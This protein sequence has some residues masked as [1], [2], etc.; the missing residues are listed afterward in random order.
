VLHNASQI[1]DGEH[2][3][4][5][6]HGDKTKFQR[7]DAALVELLIMLLGFVACEQPL[8]FRVAFP[9]N[10][11]DLANEFATAISPA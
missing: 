9:L 3:C 7:R 11:T 8:L 4:E 2:Q 5:Q 10:A 1:E 6:R